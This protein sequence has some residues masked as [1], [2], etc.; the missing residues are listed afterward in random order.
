MVLS[1]VVIRPQGFSDPLSLSVLGF[2][3][4][5]IKGSV[6]EGLRVFEV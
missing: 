3:Q 2:E 5:R 1:S 4:F 6:L